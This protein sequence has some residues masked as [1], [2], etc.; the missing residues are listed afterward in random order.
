MSTKIIQEIDWNDQELNALINYLAH[1]IL[2]SRHLGML[3]VEDIAQ[4]IKIKM[5]EIITN[6]PTKVE[7]YNIYQTAYFASRHITAHRKELRRQHKISYS[8][9]KPLP[10][11]NNNHYYYTPGPYR[12]QPLAWTIRRE[13]QAE[14]RLELEKIFHDELDK[15]LLAFLEMDND[16][17]YTVTTTRERN[18]QQYKLNVSGLARCMGVNQEI[19]RYRLQRYLQ[20]YATHHNP[21]YR[22]KSNS[23]G[24]IRNRQLILDYFRDNPHATALTASQQLGIAKSSIHRHLNLL[25]AEGALSRRGRGNP[26]VNLNSDTTHLPTTR[27]TVL[28]HYRKNPNSKA[29]HV[30]KQI[31]LNKSV[32]L[33]HLRR[34]EQEGIL[35]RNGPG[36]PGVTFDPNTTYRPTTRSTV[37]AHY[38]KNPN[39]TATHVARQIGIDKTAVL[40]HLKR[41]E[42]EGVLVRNGR[43]RPGVTFTQEP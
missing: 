29:A 8:L 21:D 20:H 10:N 42:A 19:L 41:L 6:D 17:R 27:A 40:Y 24:F 35:T 37:L 1:K 39:A 32:V 28:A 34:L 4:E 31:G 7:K 36:Y 23:P 30:A 22:K 2:F 3:T 33:Y 5:I 14:A 25:E 16:G 12:Y 15:W 13:N 11:N 26:G 9:D 43:G 18:L 38:R